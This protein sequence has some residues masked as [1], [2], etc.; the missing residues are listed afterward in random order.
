MLKMINSSLLYDK[1]AKECQK[2]GNGQALTNFWVALY[3]EESCSELNRIFVLPKEEYLRKLKQCTEPHIKK[4]EDCLS[5]TYKFYPK[6]VNSLAESLINFLYQH[7]NF[8]TLTP[9]SDLVNCLQRIKSVGGIQSN[10][11][12]C[13]KNRFQN[14]TFDFENPDRTAICKLLGQVNDCIRNFVNNTCVAD[15]AVDTVLGNFTL[16]IEAP[17]SN[18]T[19]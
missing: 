10:L 6:F 19:N 1:L 2:T 11:L 16:A 4:L 8:K 7:M 13:L 17:C 3:A 12:S 5:E 14:E 15:I 18:I 9:K